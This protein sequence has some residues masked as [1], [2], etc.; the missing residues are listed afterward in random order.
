MKELTGLPVVVNAQMVR[1]FLTVSCNLSRLQISPD[2]GLLLSSFRTLPCDEGSLV[3]AL[4]VW[5]WLKPN[6]DT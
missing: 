2:S 1:G 4:A 6:V 5:K 3:C